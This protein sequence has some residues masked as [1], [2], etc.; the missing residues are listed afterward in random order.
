MADAGLRQQ[1]QS[2]GVDLPEPS[3]VDGANVSRLSVDGLRRDVPAL[4]AKG[5]YLD[6]LRTS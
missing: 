5:Q 3:E 6:R 2:L 1:L 4:K